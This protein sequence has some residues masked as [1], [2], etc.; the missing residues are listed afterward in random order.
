[1]ERNLKNRL[2]AL[3]RRSGATGHT[4]EVVRC[5]ADGTQEVMSTLWTHHPVTRIL[6]K[7]GEW[8]QNDG[9]K[10]SPTPGESTN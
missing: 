5:W 2:A 8:R 3:E 6:V 4:C 9:T 1:M 10:A 7:Y